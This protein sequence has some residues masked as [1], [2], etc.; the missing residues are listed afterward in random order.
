[1]ESQ[2]SKASRVRSRKRHSKGE[3]TSYLWGLSGVQIT[4]AWF[5]APRES[6][7]L[8]SAFNSLLSP[9]PGINREAISYV[10][11]LGLSNPVW[12]SLAQ[13]FRFAVSTVR[14]N[15][16]PIVYFFKLDS[17]LLM[18]QHFCLYG[19]PK[20]QICPSHHTVTG[21]RAFCVLSDCFPAPGRVQ[22]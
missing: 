5:L 7:Q 20:P 1:M 14:S 19:D 3:F 12:S 21:K 17:A 2:L 22:G 9:S 18:N 6:P 10:L 4:S 13:A 11:E 8:F 16:F 15:F